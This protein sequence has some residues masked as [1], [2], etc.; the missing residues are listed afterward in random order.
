MLFFYNPT[1]C[2]CVIPIGTNMSMKSFYHVLKM[3]AISAQCDWSWESCMLWL[4]CWSEG[5]C[6]GRDT[7]W[8]RGISRLSVCVSV[9]LATSTVSQW[10][11]SLC[12]F[13]PK[14]KEKEKTSFPLTEYKNAFNC[15]LAHV[16][17][18]TGVT[19][20]SLCAGHKEDEEVSVLL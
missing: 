7:V 6:S 4:E 2:F 13:V 19:A 15:G 12:Y 3:D 10:T 16:I 17:S 14:E 20:S 5:E 9:A 18:L 8:I 11:R 1:K